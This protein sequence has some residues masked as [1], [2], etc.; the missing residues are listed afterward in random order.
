MK[1]RV[2]ELAPRPALPAGLRAAAGGGRQN[3]RVEWA[4][5]T[6]SGAS[7]FNPGGG[8]NAGRRHMR[9]A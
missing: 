5:L 4:G 8:F 6:V 9:R 1:L 2:P 7:F 3:G